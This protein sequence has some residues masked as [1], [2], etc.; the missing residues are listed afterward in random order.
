MEG[1]RG[2]RGSSGKGPEL[3][4]AVTSHFWPASGHTLANGLLADPLKG[5]VTVHVIPLL[6]NMDTVFILPVF[7]A[8]VVWLV[9]VPKSEGR[10][11]YSTR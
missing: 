9:I 7:V 4:A 6:L 2:F 8:P 1:P 3:A 10:G 5:G 11:L